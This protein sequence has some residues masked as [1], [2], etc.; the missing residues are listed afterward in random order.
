LE[1]VS[2]V[3]GLA[4]AVQRLFDQPQLARIMADAGLTVMHANQGALQRLLAMLA[5]VAKL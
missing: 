1:E 5:R 4:V 3:A 2:D